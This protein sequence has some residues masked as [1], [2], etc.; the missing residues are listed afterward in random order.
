MIFSCESQAGIALDVNYHRYATSDAGNEYESEVLYLTC[1]IWQNIIC[2]TQYWTSCM[3]VGV[4]QR[5]RE[6]KSARGAR[7][8][9]VAERAPQRPGGPMQLTSKWS[10]PPREESLCLACCSSYVDAWLCSCIKR[11]Q[12][13][14]LLTVS[15]LS[16]L[17]HSAPE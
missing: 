2:D 11:M 12:V 3:A 16:T 10:Y 5:C 4:L 1:V 13:Y 17:R 8:A 15:P 7:A 14:I 6:E 9:D